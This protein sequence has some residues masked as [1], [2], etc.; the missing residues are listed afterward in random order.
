MDT[1]ALAVCFMPFGSNI[2]ARQPIPL[3]LDELLTLH[4]VGI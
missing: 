1:L 3:P 4:P 2:V